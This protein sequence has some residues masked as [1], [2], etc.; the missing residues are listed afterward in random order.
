MDNIK[1]VINL[2]SSFFNTRLSFGSVSFSIWQYFLALF[3]LSAI[4]YAIKRLFE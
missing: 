2:V 1:L 3:I 4:F